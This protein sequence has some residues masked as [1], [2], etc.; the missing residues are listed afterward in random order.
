MNPFELNCL[1]DHGNSIA[2]S[3]MESMILASAFIAAHN[4]DL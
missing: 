3:Y 1:D 2:Y 4:S